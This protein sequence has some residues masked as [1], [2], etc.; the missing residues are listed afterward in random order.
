MAVLLAV[1]VGLPQD[2]EWQGKTVH[3]AVWK[4]PV[5]GRVMVRRLNIDGDGQ[6]DLGGHGGEHRAVMVYQAASYR[7]WENFLGRTTL[8]YGS[9]GENLTVDGL[10][11][12]EVAIGDRYRI[13]DAL[14][15]Q[16]ASIGTK[17]ERHAFRSAIND[18]AQQ[19]LHDVRWRTTFWSASSDPCLQVADY[20]AWAIQRGY[21]RGDYR[22]LRQIERHVA[23]CHDLYASSDRHYY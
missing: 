9:F 12:D 22:R 15:I 20:C 2:I 14:L 21:E 19:T 1:N 13:G 3:T 5:S 10:A 16:A 18:V 23:T 17:R 8:D 11:D 7:Y 6:G 4:R